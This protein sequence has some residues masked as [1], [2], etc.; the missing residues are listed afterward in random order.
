ML[1]ER[2]VVHRKTVDIAIRISA[3][4]ETVKPDFDFQCMPSIIDGPTKQLSVA[5]QLRRTGMET[6]L[7]IKSSLGPANRKT[8]R[9]L[10]RLNFLA[11]EITKMILQ[12][13]Q[14]PELTANRIMKQGKLSPSW[15]TQKKQLDIA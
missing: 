10:L 9:S 14:P 3:I 11:P 1:V 4:A 15:T 6:K 2:I 7:L 8:D 13:R 12:G 5:A